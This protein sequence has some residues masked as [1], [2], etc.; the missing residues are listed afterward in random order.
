VHFAVQRV[1]VNLGIN[2]KKW[3]SV[4]LVFGVGLV[5]RAGQ[6]KVEFE[7]GARVGYAIPQGKMSDEAVMTAQGTTQ[8]NEVKDVVEGQVPLGLELG[9]RVLPMLTLGGY[10]EVAPGILGSWPSDG[11]DAVD[12]DC[13]VL[14][15]GVGLM[16]SLHLLPH[17][18]VDPWLGLG[19]G[20]ELVGINET[21]TKDAKF[22]LL[23]SGVEFPLRAGVDFKLSERFYLG[24]HVGYSFGTF[25]G[26]S[27][28]C[29]G[30]RCPE[31]QSRDIENTA[32]HSW[33]NFGAKL[34]ILAY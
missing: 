9:V 5:T 10:A 27:L 11:C 28:N 21:V 8:Q 32:G 22:T 23:Y 26:V 20:L 12:H 7:V 1:F 4:V 19:V 3:L 31:D 34:T 6:A 29:E 16:A 25:S 2:M 24:P 14:S 33:Y 15:F 30:S 17:Q 18:G 13:S